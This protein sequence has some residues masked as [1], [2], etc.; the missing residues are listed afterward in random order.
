MTCV[1]SRR[2]LIRAIQR[3]RHPVAAVVVETAAA[4]AAVPTEVDRQQAVVN[5]VVPRQPKA[6]SIKV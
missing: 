3:G 4:I 2:R 5:H 1:R 6:I